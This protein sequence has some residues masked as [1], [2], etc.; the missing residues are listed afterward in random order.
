MS[1]RSAAERAEGS[2]GVLRSGLRPKD[3]W[4]AWKA[5]LADFRQEI[6]DIPRRE[7]P[8]KVRQNKAAITPIAKPSTFP[9]S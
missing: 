1:Q 2:R 9:Y 7:L 5:A 4:V 8:G 6:Q 3:S